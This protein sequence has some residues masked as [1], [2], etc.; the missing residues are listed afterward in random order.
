MT[1]LGTCRDEPDCDAAFAARLH[2]VNAHF[3]AVGMANRAPII[4]DQITTDVLAD[5]R[6]ELNGRGHR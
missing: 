6:K 3:V 4:P 2:E 1:S 5:P